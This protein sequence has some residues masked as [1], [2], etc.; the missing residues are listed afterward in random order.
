MCLRCGKEKAIID[1]QYGILNCLDCQNKDSIPL[2]KKPM[3]YDRAKQNRIQRG[4]DTNSKDLEQP[5][6]GKDNTPNRNFAKAYPDKIKDYFSPEQIK[7]LD[8]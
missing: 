6:M 1:P 2:S 4:W 5:F 7:S 8:I 3:F